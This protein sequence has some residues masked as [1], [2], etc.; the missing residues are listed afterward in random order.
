M[1]NRKLFIVNHRLIR[2]N[3]ILTIIW[4]NYNTESSL[5][6]LLIIFKLSSKY[7]LGIHVK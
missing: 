4:I 3:F 5:H 2:N 1:I 7:S 6:I